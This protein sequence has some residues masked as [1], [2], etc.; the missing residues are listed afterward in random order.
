MPRLWSC[1][2]AIREWAGDCLEPSCRA[3][4]EVGARMA[5]ESNKVNSNEMEYVRCGLNRRMMGF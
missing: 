2:A 5:L 1:A 4:A 3:R